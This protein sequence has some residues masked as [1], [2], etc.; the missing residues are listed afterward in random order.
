MY[1][2]DAAVGFARVFIGTAFSGEQRH[3]RR[4]AEVAEY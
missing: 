1:D 2:T 3:A 4:L